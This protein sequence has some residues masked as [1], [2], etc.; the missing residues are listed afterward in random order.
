MLVTPSG[1]SWFESVTTLV[2]PSRNVT[3]WERDNAC[4]VLKK[5]RDLG[6]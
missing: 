1:T 5:R 6:A 2:M 4:Y 3:V